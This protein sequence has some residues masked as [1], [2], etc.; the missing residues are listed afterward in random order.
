MAGAN[1]H[2]GH[3]QVE[4]Q[5]QGVQVKVNVQS[6]EGGQADRGTGAV[7]QDVF[8]ESSVDLEDLLNGSEDDLF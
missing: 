4:E 8:D 7:S 5:V 2:G 1:V 6:D 3:D